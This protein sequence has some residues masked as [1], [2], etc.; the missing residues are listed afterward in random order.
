M[1]PVIDPKTRTILAEGDFP[2]P[3][4]TTNRK[5]RDQI[6]GGIFTPAILYL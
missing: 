6:T 5:T 2:M 3:R 1:L 4:P